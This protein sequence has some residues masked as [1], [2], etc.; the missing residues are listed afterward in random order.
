MRYVI[1]PQAT[2]IILPPLTNQA[3]NLIKN[4]SVLAIIAGGDLMYRADSWA[5]NGALSYGPAYMVTGVLYFLLCFPLAT[6]AR[7]YEEWLKHR[8][9]AVVKEAA[10]C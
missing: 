8:H 6:W 5:A 4:T 7:R 9:L 3:V 10:E 2:Q 1:L